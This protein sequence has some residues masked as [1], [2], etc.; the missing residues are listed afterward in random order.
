MKYIKRF[1]ESEEQTYNQVFDSI[2]DC[3][4]EFEDNEWEW[5]KGSS[6]PGT[7]LVQGSYHPLPHFKYIMRKR[8][9][10]NYDPYPAF[11]YK[12][13]EFTGSINSNGEIF[14]KTQR[15][16]YKTNFSSQEFI[17]F[18]VAIKRIQDDTGLDLQFSYQ[19]QVIYD[20][21]LGGLGKRITI[22]GRIFGKYGWAESK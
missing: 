6:N 3:F 21:N 20:K 16:T 2:K 5:S 10:N 15:T 19:N 4:Q 12:K 17:D 9:H 14:W 13:F 18:V 11:D 8:E 1:S 7:N 22:Q